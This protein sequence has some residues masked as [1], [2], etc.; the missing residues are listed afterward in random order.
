MEVWKV[1][2]ILLFFLGFGIMWVHLAL[3]IALFLL[4]IIILV[5]STIWNTSGSMSDWVEEH[6]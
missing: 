5:I 4:S 6:K 3:G 2:T 1:A